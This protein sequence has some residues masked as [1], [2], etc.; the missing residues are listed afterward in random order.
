MTGA[1]EQ[2]KTT[3]PQAGPP[4]AGEAPFDIGRRV[5]SAV[6]LAALS[7]WSLWAGVQTF[8]LLLAVLAT[9]VAWEWGR[10]VRG[11]E[12]D[13]YLLAH[14]FAVVGATG[15]GAFGLGA[16]GLILLL[17]VAPV[18]VVLRLG[19]GGWLTGLGV[20][21]VGLPALALVWFRADPLLGVLAVLF[22]FVVVWSSDTFAFLAGR[23]IGGPKLWPAVSPG[24]TWAGAVG[25]A[26]AGMIAGALFAWG[27][28]G[29]DPITL[30][31]V[32]LVLSLAAQLGD[33]GESAL[34]RRAGRKDASN[35][36]PGHG[37]IFDRV[38]GLMLA[39]IVAG[40]ISLVRDFSHPAS[41]LLAW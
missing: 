27:A 15:L 16:L 9:I 7:L 6:L 40:L 11:S 33:L 21:Y 38:D 8:A 14:G 12:R 5:A 26:V 2:G 34:K 39:A 25:G 18:L 36:V 3:A 37:G 17:V 22:V 30:V 32:G 4:E 31:P 13:I 10:L 23:L 20:L 19:K 28:G 35:L 24:K 41:A 29:I 1:S